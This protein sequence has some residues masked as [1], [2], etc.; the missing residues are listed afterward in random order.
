MEAHGGSPG[1]AGQK[2]GWENRLEDQADV[3]SIPSFNIY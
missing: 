1:R 2:R 3:D